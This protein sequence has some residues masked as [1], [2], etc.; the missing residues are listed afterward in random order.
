MGSPI[1]E[2]GTQV[3]LMLV[4]KLLQI[5]QIL[6]RTADIHDITPKNIGERYP[7]LVKHKIFISQNKKMASNLL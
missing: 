2:L 6:S 1:H 5:L 7:T 4:T 3:H